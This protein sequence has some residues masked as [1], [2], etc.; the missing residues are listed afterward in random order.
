MAGSS[1]CRTRPSGGARTCRAP[2]TSRDRAVSRSARGRCTCPSRAASRPP[3]RCRREPPPGGSPRAGRASLRRSRGPCRAWWR[4]SLTGWRCASGARE[5]PVV[6][7]AE[8]VQRRDQELLSS[9][10]RRSRAPAPT[11]GA[12]IRAPLQAD[13][14]ALRRPPAPRAARSP[15][16]LLHRGSAAQAAEDPCRAV[17]GGWAARDRIG[18]DRIGRERVGSDRVGRRRAGL[19]SLGGA[20]GRGPGMGGQHHLGAP[21][22]WLE[23]HRAAR[24]IALPG[25][26]GLGLEPRDP[27]LT[28]L[29]RWRASAAASLHSAHSSGG[30]LTRVRFAVSSV[31]P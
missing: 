7:L 15:A 30:D 17:R 20:P 11:G 29:A 13:P 3:S 23:P 26:G 14:A 6:C 5:R 8:A 25:N 28:E 27:D 18:R 19:S 12:A 4:A 22:R 9:R 24:T 21:S 16:R 31:M 1:A 10:G 2:G